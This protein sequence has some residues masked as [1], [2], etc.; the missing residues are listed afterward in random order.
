MLG[1]LVVLSFIQNTKSFCPV[2]VGI[3]FC[4]CIFVGNNLSCVPFIGWARLGQRPTMADDY[5]K[6]LFPSSKT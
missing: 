5:M 1:L 6:E 3:C 4:V 2:V